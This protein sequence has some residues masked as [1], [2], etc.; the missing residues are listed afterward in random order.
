[1]G[2]MH[3]DIKPENVFLD[4]E[5]RG[6]LGDFGECADA[7]AAQTLECGSPAYFAPEM[8]AGGGYDRRVDVWAVG[9][10]LYEM[11]TGSWPFPLALTLNATKEAISK[12]GFRDGAWANVPVD[13]QAVIRSI[14][15]RDPGQ[16]LSL[17]GVLGHA[18][19]TGHVGSGEHEAAVALG[20]ELQERASAV[21]ALR[22]ELED[23]EVSTDVAEARE[24]LRR[25]V[26]RG[27]EGEP[28]FCRL[29]ERYEVLKK[30]ARRCEDL[31]RCTRQSSKTDVRKLLAALAAEGLDLPGGWLVAG[32][33]RLFAAAEG[34]ALELSDHAAA[35]RGRASGHSTKKVAATAA[36]GA[37]G[38]WG[39]GPAGFVYGRIEGLP[40]QRALDVLLCWASE[41]R[42]R[43]IALDMLGAVFA[44]APSDKARVVDVVSAAGAR[45]ELVDLL[46]IIEQQGMWPGQ[47]L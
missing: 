2:W 1:M 5:D 26:S 30:Q 33:P 22:L 38:E 25:A 16:R 28:L 23:L 19:L 39:D 40:C 42:L 10:L 47:P 36:P 8:C 15:Q 43:P 37:V 45:R 3:R 46:D 12:L 7:S 34:W 21:A 6:K 4:G 11:L 13:A 14:L 24:V 41:A 29:A 27:M 44:G 17:L 32:G 35:C 9:I 18:W 20:R 31:L